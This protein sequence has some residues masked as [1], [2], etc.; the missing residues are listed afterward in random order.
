M[1]KNKMY[2]LR[3]HFNCSRSDSYEV[4]GRDK[5]KLHAFG[6]KRIRYI[7]GLIPERY[8]VITDAVIPNVPHMFTEKVMKSKLGEDMQV[9][10]LFDK[11]LQIKSGIITYYTIM[12][13]EEIK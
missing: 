5:K 4:I 7:Y 11:L 13:I 8:S 6:E 12:E 10:T 1:K 2:I 3:I 9:F